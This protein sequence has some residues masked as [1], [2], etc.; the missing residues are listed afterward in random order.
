MQADLLHVF[1]P[2]FDPLRWKTPRLLYD[3]FVQ[4]MLD[5]GVK[6]HVIEL[7]YGERPFTCARPHVDH[8]GVRASTAA[9]AKENLINIGIRRTPEAKYL[10]WIDADVEFRRPDW[11][12]ES[13]HALQLYPVI[14]PW[15]HASDLG[16]NGV[17][18][19]QHVSFAHQAMLGAPVVPAG[20]NF[21]RYDG[22]PYDYP[23]TGFGWGMTRDAY[24]RVGGL[25]DAGGMGS[26]DH[27]MA[28]ALIGQAE[29]SMPG[30]VHPA[31]RRQVMKWQ[32]RALLHINQKIGCVKGLMEH[33]HHGC[34]INRNYQ[35]RWDTVTRHQF[36]PD[37]DLIVNSHGVIEW[38]GNKPHL[39]RDF[40]LY[41]QDRREDMAGY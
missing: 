14:Q 37:E 35:G 32:A 34:K 19:A 41:L 38:A 12:V 29:R 17:P 7:Q 22:G 5:S 3:R 9:W 39:E 26:G 2:Q 11:A 25:F 27:H 31:Y 15:S 40:M 18:I 28:L 10:A 16:P 33:G 21:W 36:N 23:H 4:H 20:P 6:L 30:G 13:V 24:N 8:I 1:V